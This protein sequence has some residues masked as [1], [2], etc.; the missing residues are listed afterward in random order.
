MLDQQLAPSFSFLLFFDRFEHWQSS[1]K[2]ITQIW[3]KRKVEICKI[4]GDM[5]ELIVSKYGDFKLQK[6]HELCDVVHYQ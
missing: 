6:I 2:G 4:F 1:T 5:L 3:S